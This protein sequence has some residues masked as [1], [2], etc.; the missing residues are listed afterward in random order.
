MSS[1]KGDVSLSGGQLASPGTSAP[2]LIPPGTPGTSRSARRRGAAKARDGGGPSAAATSGSKKE[3]DKAVHK[4]FEASL[5]GH[6]YLPYTII[7]S[8]SPSSH[9]PTFSRDGEF[10]FMPTGAAVKVYSR[11][12]GEVVSTLS[13]PQRP[14]SSRSTKPGQ[15]STSSM[16]T[17][18]RITCICLHPLN[19][20]RLV[21]GCSDGSIRIWDYMEG[22]MLQTLPIVPGLHISHIATVGDAYS[23]RREEI[24]ESLSKEEQ[25]K[26]MD[27]RQWVFVVLQKRKLKRKE[28]AAKAQTRTEASAETIQ[29]ETRA[30]EKMEGE[31]DDGE[32][33]ENSLIYAVHLRYSLQANRGIEHNRLALRLGKT[34]GAAADLQASA[35]GRFLVCIG[36]KK[37]QIALLEKLMTAKLDSTQASDAPDAAQEMVVNGGVKVASTSNAAA[38]QRRPR[39]KSE[40]Q[41]PEEG[42]IKFATTSHLTCLAL[43]HDPE[44]ETV[45]TGDENGVIRLWHSCLDE[46]MLMKIARD[47]EAM[48]QLS[49]ASVNG[50]VAT[51][52]TDKYLASSTLHW[53]AHAVASL[54][55]SYN[56]AQLISGGEEAVLVI[57]QIGA[58]GGASGNQTKKEFVPRLRA[59]IASVA[60]I[61]GYEGRDG[62][63]L[64]TLKDGSIAFI[65]GVNLKPSRTLARIR[66][67]P[68]RS[69]LPESQR[70]TLPMPLAVEPVSGA[71]VLSGSHPSELQ[72]FHPSNDT[73]AYELEVTPSNRVSRPDE[74]FIEPIRVQH[75]AFA[76]ACSQPQHKGSPLG[77]SPWMAVVDN[78]QGGEGV[79]QE[80]ALTFWQ[81]RPGKNSTGYNLI[82][83]IHKP[84][85]KELTAMAFSPRA[86]LSSEAPVLATSSYDGTARIWQ[87]SSQL[88]KGN[89]REVFWSLSSVFSYRGNVARE[90]SF[91]PDGTLLAVAHGTAVTIWDLTSNAMRLAFV[92]PD[93][94]SFYHVCIGGRR[95][96]FVAAS[97]GKIAIVWDLITQQVVLRHVFPGSGIISG[98]WSQG[99][100]QP[101]FVIALD[102][103]STG[104]VH[105]ATYD[106]QHASLQSAGRTSFS[107]RAIAPLASRESSTPSLRAITESFDLVDIG[108]Q[109]N[110][111]R[112]PAKSRSLHTASV[113]RRSL[114]Q[115]LF[116]SEEA[117][118]PTHSLG[119]PSNA[120]AAGGVLSLFTAPAHLLPS[121]ESIFTPFLNGILPPKPI[122]AKAGTP[123]EVSAASQGP[124]DEVSPLRPAQQP[125]SG[126]SLQ[127]IAAADLTLLTR[128]FR[129]V[130]SMSAT[131]APALSNGKAA[132]VNVLARAP[133]T[134]STT[135]VSSPNTAA[136]KNTPGCSNKSPK[137]NGSGKKRK[138]D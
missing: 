92:L 108:P 10:F 94:K 80:M 47:D 1:S 33:R 59:P 127:V 12:T 81:A 28:R 99:S 100:Q 27:L 104:E 101:R 115:D 31:Q 38:K 114:F 60:E 121:M 70:R 112:Q 32:E 2:N 58:A 46:E 132:K 128:T 79:S 65:S 5:N 51:E 134:P 82:S 86:Q 40:L 20:L 69:M 53:H 119:V 133:A 105:F 18:L 4:T 111:S 25:D 68:T 123:S 45:A 49:S 67:D 3:K 129:D 85:E 88:V 37:L 21:A 103:V 7:R 124:A 63:Y 9:S 98:V 54:A 91:S 66:M 43:P 83:R 97:G 106:P 52:A 55:W 30:G 116:G 135:V 26:H 95:G 125:L 136:S 41:G 8:G 57:W 78:R 77:M 34:R 126:N 61:R 74:E 72:F 117:P 64:V 73:L 138:A 11:L 29:T 6:A 120:L 122:S 35:D 102:E 96:R 131:P 48:R 22:A 76:P 107:L 90:I 71:L 14:S 15:P 24:L 44:M 109:A 39:Q 118:Q 16:F 89:R 62:E 17:D 110:E 23:E 130:L 19:P 42:F 84:H 56:D 93:V 13:I 75:V 87:L 137:A 36:N 113:S 50:A